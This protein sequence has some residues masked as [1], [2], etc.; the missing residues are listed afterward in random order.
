MMKKQK[1]EWGEWS[2][3]HKSL[4]SDM[5]WKVRAG[6]SYKLSK[7]MKSMGCEGEGI[8]SSDINHSMFGIWKSVGKDKKAYIDECIE[9]YSQRLYDAMEAI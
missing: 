8:G 1:D 4:D 2:D 6:A 9:L 3:M 7:E 5:Q